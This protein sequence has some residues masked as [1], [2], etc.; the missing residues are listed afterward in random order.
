MGYVIVL[1]VLCILLLECGMLGKIQGTKQELNT[2]QTQSPDTGSDLNLV[3]VLKWIDTILYPFHCF[4][5]PDIPTAYKYTG[6]FK[7]CSLSNEE[8]PLNHTAVIPGTMW[9]MC[10][11]HSYPTLPHSLPRNAISSNIL[12]TQT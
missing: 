11:K 9:T 2:A 6:F 1:T 4:L 5:R 10:S 3:L 8:N 12:Q 7:L